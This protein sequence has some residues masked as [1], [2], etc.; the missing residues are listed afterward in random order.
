MAGCALAG[1]KFHPLLLLIT[2]A[3]MGG[4]A[5]AILSPLTLLVNQRCL[6]KEMQPGWVS[7]VFLVWATLL[8]GSFALYTLWR[9]LRAFG[10]LL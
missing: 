5:M 1:L 2:G 6:P 3:C 7:K 10:K 9:V 4:V 8:Y